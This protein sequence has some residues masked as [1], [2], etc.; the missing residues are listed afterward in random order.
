METEEIA[1]ATAKAALD[2]QVLEAESILERARSH[3][4]SVSEHLLREARQFLA[5]QPT[6]KVSGSGDNQGNQ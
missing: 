3:P 1:E 6:K 2:R 5:S 4:G